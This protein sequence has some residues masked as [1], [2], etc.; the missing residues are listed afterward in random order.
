LYTDYILYCIK[1]EATIK[2]LL[3]TLLRGAQ[4]QFY[5]YVQRCNYSTLVLSRSV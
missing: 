2:L 1:T 4:V 3:L 5:I